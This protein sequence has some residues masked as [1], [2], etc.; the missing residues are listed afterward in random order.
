[1]IDNLLDL[2]LFTRIVAT[3]TLSAAARELGLSLAVVSKRLAQMEERLG[4]RLIQ[5]T[6]RRLALTE[7]GAVFHEH[8]LRILAEVAEAE[9]AISRTRDSVSGL[10]R[11]NAPCAF[12]RRQLAPIVAAFGRHHPDLRIQV[13]LTDTVVDLVESGADIAIRY[14]RLADSTMIARELAPSYRVLCAAPAYLERRGHPGHPLELAAHDCIVLGDASGA[15][16][17]FG[18]GEDELVVRVRGPFLCNQGEMTHMLALEGAGIAMKSIWD[19]GEDIEAGRLVQVLPSYPIPA[20]PLHAIY[21]HARH[22][23]PRVRQFVE[24]L[25]ERLRA[26]WRWGRP[27]APR[28]AR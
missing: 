17:R 4:V 19:V 10:L 8:C 2:S 13:E 11:L 18:S 3:G 26:S 25:G 14:G 24:F 6:T 28:A 16:W 22:L 5:R 15:D 7:E 27:D 9:A 12:G 23:A 20:A 21:P 1:M